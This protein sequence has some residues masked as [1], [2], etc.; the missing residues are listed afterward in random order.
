MEIIKYGTVENNIES[1]LLRK[2]FTMNALAYSDEEGLLDYSSGIVDIK[3]D[4]IRLNGVDD[5]NFKNAKSFLLRYI[6][7]YSQSL[8]NF[9]NFA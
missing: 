3:S 2:D 5:E 8:N 9:I 7:N 1:Y 4:I 6:K